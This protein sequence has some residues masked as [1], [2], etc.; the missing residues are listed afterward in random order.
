MSKDISTEKSYTVKEI[1]E[2]ISV[3]ERTIRNNIKKLYPEICS[4]GK[5][6]FLNELQ[7]SNV[8]KSLKIAHNSNLASTGQVPMTELEEMEV[9]ANAITILTRKVK[10]LQ[11]KAEMYQ[12]FIDTGDSK[13][14]GEFAKMIGIGRNTMMAKLRTLNIIDSYNIP[15]QKHAH[16]FIVRQV[17]KN[18]KSYSTT[19]I[20][21]ETFEYLKKRV[22]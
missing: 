22:I 14:M 16:R 4:Q 20:P 2:M 7:V 8:S 15:Y 13:T 9:V 11:P 12:A 18:E 1:S 3:P 21:A 6:I 17:V 5:T 19:F 10:E